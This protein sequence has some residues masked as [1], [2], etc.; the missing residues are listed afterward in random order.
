M[1]HAGDEP[2]L[3]GIGLLGHLLGMLKRRIGTTVRVDLLL[4]QP[5]LAFRFLLGDGPAL[6][7]QHQP[8]GSHCGKQHQPGTNLEK[9]VGAR[10]GAVHQWAR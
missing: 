3:G 10:R 6:V 1:A 4:Q 9:Q 2:A 5:V 8:P 7:G